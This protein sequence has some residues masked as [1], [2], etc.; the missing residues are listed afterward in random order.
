MSEFYVTATIKRED[1][2]VLRVTC[3]HYTIDDGFLW[4]IIDS[5]TMPDYEIHIKTEIEEEE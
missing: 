2:L 3:D 1:K 4:D 5:Y